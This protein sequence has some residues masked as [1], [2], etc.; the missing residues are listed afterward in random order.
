MK[1][2]KLK[3]KNFKPYYDRPGEEQE[4]L[5]FDE[6]RKDRNITLNIGPT[7]HGKTSISEAIMWCLFCDY[8]DWEKWVN[9][10]AIEVA[11]QR[12]ENVINISVELV[13]EIEKEYY[14]LIRSGGY[15]ITNG[16]K[17]G[18]SELSIIHNGEPIHDPE[19]F[20][21]KHFPSVTLMEYFV[22]DADDI[23]KKFEKSREEAIRDHI[24]KFAGVE[25]LDALI[26]SFERIMELHDEEIRYIESQIH[27]DIAE[28][29]ED[30]EKDKGEKEDAVNKLDE[31]INSLKKDRKTLFKY[32]VSPE[33]EQFSKLVDKK[34]DLEKKIGGLNEQFIDT[35]II[36]DMDLL[37]INCI[38][39]DAIEKLSQKRTTKEEFESSTEVIKSSLKKDFSGILFDNKEKTNLIKKGAKIRDD[40]L[41]S[42]EKLGLESGEGIK[43]DVTKTFIEYGKQIDGKKDA[44]E[45]YKKNF[46]EAI[47][48]LMKVR[49]EINQLGDTTKN[50][51][52]REKYKKFKKVE[53]KIKEKEKLKDEVRDK[54]KDVKIEIEDLRKQLT[55]NKDQEKEIKQIEKKKQT[56]QV[57]LDISKK[58]RKKYLDDLLF[59]VNRTASEFLQSTVKDTYRFHSIEIDSDYQFKVKQKNGKPLE[60]SQI[61]R[62]NLQISMMSFFFGLSKFLGKEIPYIIDDPLLRLDPGHDKRL[63]EQLSKTNDQLV[64]HMIPGKE[65]TT[66]SFNWL[67]P[68]INT[69]NWL[70]RKKYKNIELISYVEV[71]DANKIIYFN[72]D[73]F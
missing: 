55:R 45:K 73:Q 28:K 3:L 12:K 16:Q 59:S 29:K 19:G 52:L 46:D 72:I 49:N 51:E 71:K 4:I 70:F 62:G 48:Q 39:K 30:K 27:G 6:K 65:Y 9:T 20:I 69:Q 1:F 35:D 42:I 23:L 13:L 43:S 68:H 2:I 26:N 18:E 37:F 47:K 40:D 7:G 24:N 14:R 34:D 63:I 66:E 56:V 8:K 44:F 32:P 67:K 57:L 60:E 50:K 25:K 31:E 64:F 41:E 61:N 22:F 10:L 5:L 36:S 15:D 38:I 11:K 33:I 53:S 21:S 58:T 17:E 54:I